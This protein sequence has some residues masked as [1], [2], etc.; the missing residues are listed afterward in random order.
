MSFHSMLFLF[1]D[2]MNSI[3]VMAIKELKIRS[4]FAGFL[5]ADQF[6]S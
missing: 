2:I 6:V 3:P 5:Q 4:G 1:G